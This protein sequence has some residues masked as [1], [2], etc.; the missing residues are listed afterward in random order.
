MINRLLNIKWVDNLVLMLLISV[1]L[2]V[3]VLIGG[4]I[5]Y[6][7]RYIV[8]NNE[9]ATNGIWLQ[10]TIYLK[11]YKHLGNGNGLFGEYDRYSRSDRHGDVLTIYKD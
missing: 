2:S 1:I 10:K 8:D 5:S 7:Q 3:P 4:V 11:E 6:S 9:T